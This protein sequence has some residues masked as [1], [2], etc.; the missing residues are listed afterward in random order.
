ML[1]LLGVTCVPAQQGAAYA[2]Y[3]L[4]SYVKPPGTAPRH[5]FGAPVQ[6]NAN[7]L[8]VGG[9]ADCAKNYEA[10]R[11]CNGTV[12]LFNR[13]WIGW[14]LEAEVKAPV[15]W[16]GD[17]FGSALS[18]DAD[19]LLVGAA[20]ESGCSTGVSTS[21]PSGTGC[22]SAGAAYVFTRNSGEWSLQAYLKP[23]VVASGLT[24]GTAVAIKGDVAV[25]SAP[26]EASCTN[27]SSFIVATDTACTNAGAVY[28]FVRTGGTWA[29]QVWQLRVEHVWPDVNGDEFGR[30]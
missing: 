7:T 15:G 9:Q 14:S 16:P 8:A 18:L 20:H 4:A 3:R 6:L 28:V 11:P 22:A 21:I 27:S 24:F 30:R 25:V 2:P 23:P 5:S 19:T 26:A 13:T 17:S 1:A 12:Y 29:F 10:P